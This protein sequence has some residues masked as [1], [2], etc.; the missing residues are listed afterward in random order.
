MGKALGHYIAQKFDKCNT[1]CIIRVG[2]KFRHFEIRRGNHSVLV[3]E[4][5]ASRLVTFEKKTLKYAPDETAGT[6]F[7]GYFPNQR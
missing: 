1:P 3:P 2:Q 7:I 6:N 4:P 5:S